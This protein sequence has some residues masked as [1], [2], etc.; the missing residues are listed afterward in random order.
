LLPGFY[1][2]VLGYKD[3]GA[4][5]EAKH[6]QKIVPGNNGVFTPSVILNGCVAGTW[7]RVKSVTVT[8]S[9]FKRFTRAEIEA[10]RPAAERYG[11]FL[12]LPV[13]L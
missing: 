11:K 13:N 2:F 10:L 9:G 1:E 4:V 7:Q 12:G 3:R 8:T 5:L 6:A